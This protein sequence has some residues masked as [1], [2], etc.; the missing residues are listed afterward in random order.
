[1]DNIFEYATSEFS[2]D[3]FLCWLFSISKN[4][5][6]NI[7][8][9]DYRVSQ[10][11]LNNFCK[12]KGKIIINENGIK[13]QE[14][15]IDILIEGKYDNGEEFILAI[16]NKTTSKEHSDQ[17]KRYKNYINEK[18]KHIKK[19]KRH[20]IYYK[21][22][23]QSNTDDIIKEEYSI[24]QINEIFKLLS[25]YEAGKSKNDILR[26][27]FEFIE[28]EVELYDNFKKL[29]I[30]EWD[31]KAFQGFFNYLLP[32]L[33]R[34]KN[35]SNHGFGYHD[36]PNGG[37]W[38]LWFGDDR[39]IKNKNGEKIGFHLNLETA[40]SNVKKDWSCR[41]IIRANERND[42]SKWRKSDIEQYIGKI[43][44]EITNKTGKYMILSKLFQIDNESRIYNYKELEKK[45]MMELKRFI[46]WQSEEGFM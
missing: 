39:K 4:D 34:N 7:N 36:N 1:M 37:H 31:D 14:G 6:L 17:L 24:F 46:E 20:F 25:A 10:G 45:I 13:R 35:I 21:T 22:T 3:A 5:N 27:Y 2:N 40:N 12:Y 9:I 41:L 38:S 32:K 11:Y 42:G 16:E 18:Y 23:I 19:N 15:K 28:K 30:N 26:N 29:N 33:K 8:S 44:K 43:G